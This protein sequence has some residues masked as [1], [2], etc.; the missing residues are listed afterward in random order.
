MNQKGEQEELQLLLRSR[1]P[2]LVVETAEERRFL[3]LIETVANLN[4][5]ALFTWSVVQ[6]LRRPLKNESIAV[7]RE[8]IDALQEIRKSPQNGIYV[9]F[10]A[11]PWLD[12]PAVV[13]LIREIAHEY[14]QTH[15]TL[16]FVGSKVALH[17]DVQRM[18]ASFRLAPTGPDEVRAIVKEEFEIY[19]YNMGLTGL[20]GEQVAYEM[21][22]QH[23]VG[24]SRDD[25]RRM[26]R[27]SIEHEGKIT[28]EDVARV[29]QLKHD[30]LGED[31]TL[32]M[33][34]E[35]ESRASAGA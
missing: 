22:I 23:L 28:M 9:F 16:V 8:L 33:V 20:R 10:D 4:E 26:V 34:T 19:N 13:R 21:L 14:Q 18:S 3:A 17:S 12:N 29:L 32:T 7:S 2:I 6:G 24:L 35:I 15:R 5:S 27:Q 11:T 30:S 1:F 25:A 31:G